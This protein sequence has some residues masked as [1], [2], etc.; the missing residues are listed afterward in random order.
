MA[1]ATQISAAILAGGQSRRMGIDKRWVEIDAL[2]L[3]ARAV[4]SACAVSDDVVVVTSSPDDGVNRSRHADRDVLSQARVARDLRPGCGPLAG[5]ETALSVARHPTVVVVAV[6]HPWLHVEVLKLLAARLDE[7]SAMVAMLGTDRGPQPLVAAYDRRAVAVVTALLD[8]GERR[9][10]AL[11]DALGAE[12]VRPDAWMQADPSGLTGVD[13]DTPE[14][15]R[16]A[17]DARSVHDRSH[18]G[19]GGAHGADSG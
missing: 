14:A 1:H 5:I 6:D 13:V 17:I 3:L 19:Q 15:L 9:A 8:D 16:R 2:P 18:A 4:H 7:S 10:L 12:V 11:I